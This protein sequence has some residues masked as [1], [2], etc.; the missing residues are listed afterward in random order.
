MKHEGEKF[1]E[2]MVV[3]GSLERLA[4]V[5]MTAFVA[6]IGLVPLAL[7]AGETGKELLHPLAIVVIGGLLDS[8]LM[9]QIVTP[10]V[11]FLLGRLYLFWFGRNP[12]LDEE[13]A[14]RDGEV[15]ERWAETQ[16]PP[17]S[18]EADASVN[19]TNVAVPE[20]GRLAEPTKS[21]SS[22]ASSSG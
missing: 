15:M 2:Q 18:A 17:P 16:F 3:R 12:Y 20:N 22:E 4:P 19:S 1:D 10:A 9:D 13:S 11:F 6:M 14:F 5:L 21:V 8:T 7:G